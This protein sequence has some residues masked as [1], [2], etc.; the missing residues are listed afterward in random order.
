MQIVMENK[1]L[2]VKI[3]PE[4]LTREESFE[5]KAFW[6]SCMISSQNPR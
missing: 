4:E 5:K 6:A 3:F 1:W 2:L